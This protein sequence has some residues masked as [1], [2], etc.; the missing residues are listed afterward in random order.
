M[1]EGESWK[2]NLKGLE[3]RGRFE[4]GSYPKAVGR[5]VQTSEERSGQ[6]KACKKFIDTVVTEGKHYAK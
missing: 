5:S 2:N 1:S 4:S 6:L 3:I